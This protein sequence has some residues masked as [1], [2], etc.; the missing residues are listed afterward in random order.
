[1]STSGKKP[2]SPFA[3]LAK[4]RD[5]LPEGAPVPDA[6]PSPAPEPASPLAGKI[7]VARTRKGRGGKTVTL[8]S[9]MSARGEA[10]DALA[11]DLRQALGCG[12]AVEDG[13]RIVVQ[14]DQVS[15]VRELLASMGARRIVV[16]S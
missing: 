7:V 13:E 5:E 9:G 14:G 16:G 6:A 11:R 2:S 12:A 1:V 15:R 4:L 10:L 8:V 3:V